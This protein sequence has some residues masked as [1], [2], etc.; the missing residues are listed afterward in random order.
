MVRPTIE[1]GSQVLTYQ[2]HYLKSLNRVPK[3]LNILTNF[4]EKLE[5]FQT[6]ALKTLIGSPKSTSPAIVRLF[7]GV[8]PLKSRLDMLKLRYFWK[9]THLNDQSVAR[10]I[11]KYRREHFFIT[12]NGFIH[13][14]FNLC[15]KY[16]VIDFWHGKLKGLTNP[17]SFIKDKILS[18]SLK[19][20]LS[21]GRKR[22][23]AFT[24]IYLSNIF[25]YKKS[26]Y[27]VEPFLEKYFF[28]SASASRDRKFQLKLSLKFHVEI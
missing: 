20:D 22:S 11:L 26:Y 1:Y 7:S 6:K 9:L 24:D 5:Q 15:C 3:D 19:D 28:T 4:E 27:L 13:E 16:N 12:K 14:I 23:C 18:F 2:N 8:E 21:I 10:R 17:T 25:S